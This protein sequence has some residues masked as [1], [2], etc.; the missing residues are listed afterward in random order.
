MLNFLCPL[1]RIE[2]SFDAVGVV[3]LLALSQNGHA[4]SI[5]CDIN[6]GEIRANFEMEA[7]L[8]T[9]MNKRVKAAASL[10][11]EADTDILALRYYGFG[12]LHA[13]F[14]TAI[15][16]EQSPSDHTLS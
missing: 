16:Y 14:H 2:L 5:L 12:S 15:C 9:I 3:S 4:V 8:A 7:R 6:T 10:G 13:Q 11:E 1:V